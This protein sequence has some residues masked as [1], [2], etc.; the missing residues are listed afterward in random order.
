MADVLSQNEIDDLLD[1]LNTGELD[2]DEIS[3][4][5]SGK[6]VKEYDFA[7]PAK[8]SKEQLKTLESIFDAYARKVANYLSGNLRVNATVSVLNSEA[9][10]YSEFTNS[11]SNPVILS[12]IDM[13]PLK[14]SILFELSPNIGY[15]IIERVLGG[16]GS[17][18][19]KIR[20]FTEVEKSLITRV[21]KKLL[22]FLKEPF[23]NVFKIDPELEKIE[24]NSQFAQIISPNEMVAL[25]T[26]NMKIGDVE[27]MMNI[28]L[29]YTTLEP[30]LDNLSRKY[31]FIMNE[32]KKGE[33]LE[34][35]KKDIK[36]NIENA[37]LSVKTILGKTKITVNEFT[38]LEVG[39]VIKLDTTVNSKIPVYIEDDLRFYAK[40]GKHKKKNAALITEIK[41]DEEE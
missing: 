33:M 14:N 19:D 36:H 2:V 31:W 9:L 25:L 27:G 1:A 15:S 40:P 24:T 21:M 30:I 17:T 29:P 41:D 10:T 6:K 28:C 5:M 20:E 35:F 7:R 8:F 11:L 3:D 4:D 26:L 34:D 13:K 16:E 38:N 12:I 18:M 22:T 23:E 37:N 39:D 32:K